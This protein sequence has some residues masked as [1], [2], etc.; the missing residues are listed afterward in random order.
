MTCIIEVPI[1]SQESER[2]Y[3]YIFYSY[4][5]EMGAIVQNSWPEVMEMIK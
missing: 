1:L 4:L 5:M 3:I 2:L